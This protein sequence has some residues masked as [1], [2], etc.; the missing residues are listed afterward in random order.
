MSNILGVGNEY[1]TLDTPVNDLY[2]ADGS[3][4]MNNNT[5]I[6]LQDPV[7]T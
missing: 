2:K 5:I 4:D 3:L 7:Y 1:I 6:N